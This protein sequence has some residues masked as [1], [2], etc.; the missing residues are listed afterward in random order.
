MTDAY[1]GTLLRFAAEAARNGLDLLS[2]AE[3]LCASARWSRAYALAVLAIEELG[4]ASVVLT[5]ALLP[6]EL[7]RQVPVEQLL[8]RHEVKHA[9]GLVMCVLEFGEP[10]VAARAEEFADQLAEVARGA[11]TSNLAKQRGFYVDLISGEFRRPREVT[12]AEARAALAEAQRVLESAGPLRDPD[13]LEFLSAPSPEV[14]RWLGVTIE[15][16]IESADTGGP[17][18]AADVALELMRI[19]QRR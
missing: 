2:D 12:E 4:K 14:L 8:Q 3:V 6:E 16:F 9:V 10:G 5:A 15:R 11:R 17:E 19:I 18:A 1:Q 13:V 7:R